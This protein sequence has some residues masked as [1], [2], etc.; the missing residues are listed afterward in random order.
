MIKRP[1]GRR[2][3]FCLESGTTADTKLSASKNVL[4]NRYGACTKWGRLCFS[5]ACSGAVELTRG[6]K[7]KNKKYPMEMGVRNLVRNV[8]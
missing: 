1:F 2:C 7:Q 8:C 4:A 5:T 3:G 6:D